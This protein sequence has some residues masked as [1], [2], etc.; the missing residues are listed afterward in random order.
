[1]LVRGFLLPWR[2]RRMLLRLSKENLELI[3]VL[4][5]AGVFLDIAE[6]L[7]DQRAGAILITCSDADQ[8]AEVFHHQEKLQAS[9]RSRPRIHT[10]AWHGGA[11]ACAP[12]SPINKRKHAHL[13]YLD[14]IGDAP[15]MKDINVVIARAHAPCAA[16]RDNNVGL[17]E[18]LALQF[19]AKQQIKTLNKGIVTA[20]FFDVDYGGE[21][22]RTYFVSHR[23]WDEWATNRGIRA[24][25]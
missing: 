13:V 21:R 5:G 3:G 15:A 18:V 10:F 24:I 9:Q 4:R 11:L 7:L 22:K 12:C 16:A 19:R 6:H 14:Q 2:L 8:F 1:M 20:C 25:A 23:K 17:E